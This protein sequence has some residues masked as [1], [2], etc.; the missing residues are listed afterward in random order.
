VSVSVGVVRNKIRTT[1][2]PVKVIVG[3]K[4][5]GVSVVVVRNKIRTTIAPVKVNYISF[6]AR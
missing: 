3:I 5:V 2:A 4:A 6:V 1:I